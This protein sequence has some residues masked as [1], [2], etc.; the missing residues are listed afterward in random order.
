MEK[1]RKGSVLAP[2]RR[3]HSS[4]S[5]IGQLGSVSRWLFAS[6]SV[7][8][9][10]STQAAIIAGLLSIIA[11]GFNALYFVLVLAG[12]LIAH[13]TSNLMN[14]YFG[15][16]RG[17]DTKES[18]RIRYTI[19]P[20]ADKVAS[21]SQLACAILILIVMGLLIAAYF[22]FVRGYI[23][24]A[25]LA[26]G[27][28]FLLMYDAF[29]IT[30]KS[31]GLGEIS[32]FIV[33]GPLMIGS[34]FY[35]ITGVLSIAPFLIA[36]PYG[37]GVM[38]ILVAKHIDQIGFDKS[39]KQRTLPVVMGENAARKLNI[40]TIGLMYVSTAL[41]VAFGSVTPFLLLVFLNIPMTAAALR[42]LSEKRPKMPPKGYAGWPLWYH[43][44]S[45]VHNR[46]FGWL[47]I[48]GLAAGAVV[49][50]LV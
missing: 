6:R 7:I 50:Y 44:A 2:F 19:H 26:I 3:F 11:G 12:F 13:A 32:A 43:R 40:A 22:M 38:S 10:I 36:V 14:D 35:L 24:L 8:L 21:K 1:R 25:F 17:H 9:I 37:L 47:F 31:I 23:A 48:F 16:F 5:D 46:M 20:I 39:I 42:R 33:W 41:L 4:K 29:P 45:L 15:Y 30:L 18:P 27:A 28:F 49:P 34:G